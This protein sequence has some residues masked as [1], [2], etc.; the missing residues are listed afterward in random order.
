MRPVFLYLDPPLFGERRLHKRHWNHRLASVRIDSDVRPEVAAKLANF[1]IGTLEGAMNYRHAF[2]AGNIAD[3]V[4]HAIL[5]RILTHLAE[6]SA[7]YRV[8]DTHAGAGLYDLHA[9]P[10]ERT[11]EWRGGIGRLLQVDADGTV[12]ADVRALLAPYLAAVAAS[13]SPGELRRYPG[14]PL[15]ALSLM[16]PDDRLVACELERGAAAALTANLRR[17]PRARAVAIDGWLAL[18]A[19]LPPPER[20]GLV[21][22]D[23]PFEDKEEF[24]RLG[25]ALVAALR[26]WATGTY[27]VWY[28]IKE[29]AAPDRLASL[30]RRSAS[31]TGA[32]AGLTILRAEFAWSSPPAADGE[33][34]PGGGVARNIGTGAAAK[35]GGKRGSKPA[36]TPASTPASKPAPKPGA[37][38]SG[39]D[40]AGISAGLGAA[41]LIIVNPPWRLADELARLLPALCALLVP[42]RG[43]RTK[44]DWV[45]AER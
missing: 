1:G 13:N 6:K 11:G 18:N 34:K 17:D 37:A 24:A 22:I 19:Y 3:V 44:L 45:V 25:E 15:I 31:A 10:A 36:S 16:R 35:P 28:P 42:A 7:A 21:V 4:K 38:P 14:S 30:L 2:H 33:A 9:A 8:I 32:K 27:L 12:A 20:R 26:K 5:A 40:G 43:G 29:R 23:P 41:G 39:D